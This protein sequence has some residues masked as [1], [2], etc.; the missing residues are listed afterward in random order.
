VLLDRSS[1]GELLV[2]VHGVGYRVQV[3]PS[4]LG[5]M[6]PTG[7]EIFLYCHHVQREDAQLLY[8]FPT[9]DERRIFEALLTAQ[10]VGPA[11]ALAVLTEFSPTQLRL[12]VA[13]GDVDG[14]KRIKGVGAKTAARMVIDL[15][16][17]L[18]LPDG[19][20]AAV[21][22]D[23]VGAPTVSAGAHGDVRTALAGLGYSPEEVKVAMAALPAE[24]ETGALLR[25]ALQHMAA[26]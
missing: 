16:S 11:M 17:K 18:H 9:I 25:L 6:G 24:G 8:G 21:V 20:L 2:E 22:S 10:G 19:D 14:L 1:G 12:A 7:G 13:A 26:R 4:T 15:K 5:A 3:T 23:G